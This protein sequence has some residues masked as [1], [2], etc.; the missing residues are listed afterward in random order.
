MKLDLQL[1]NL[2]HMLSELIMRIMT[3]LTRTIITSVMNMKVFQLGCTGGFC[4][5]T[6]ADNN[7]KTLDTLM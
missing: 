4:S 2:Q 5:G 1:V 7:I 6:G 3:N